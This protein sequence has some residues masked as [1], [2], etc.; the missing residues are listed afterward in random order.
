MKAFNKISINVIKQRLFDSIKKVCKIKP[1]WNMKHQLIYNYKLL[2]TSV[3]LQTNVLHT[4]TFLILV[5]F[6]HLN[7][8]SPTAV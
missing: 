3:A 7:S 1:H 2:H 4:T 5:I 6:C 8:L